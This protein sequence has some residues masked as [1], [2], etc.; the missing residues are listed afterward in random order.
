MWVIMTTLIYMTNGM[1]MTVM[2]DTTGVI[3]MSIMMLA[4][5]NMSAMSMSISMS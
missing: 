1:S 5:R 2:K 4:K 3:T